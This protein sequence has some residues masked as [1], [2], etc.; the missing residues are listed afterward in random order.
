MSAGAWNSLIMTYKYNN[1]SIDKIFEKVKN[2]EINSIKKMQFE[3]KKFLLENSNSDDYELDKLFITLC[4][5][6]NNTI[7]N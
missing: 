6:E 4:V 5:M 7:R 3:L 1:L 2:K